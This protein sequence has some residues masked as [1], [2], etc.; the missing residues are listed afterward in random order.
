MSRTR[1]VLSMTVYGIVIGS[2][3]SSL[4]AQAKPWTLTVEERIALRTNPLLARQRVAAASKGA[5][6]DEF[7]GK[8][9]PELF[10]VLLL[11]AVPDAR[12]FG[13]QGQATDE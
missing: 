4:A 9:H 3:S 7:T 5:L 13:S 1:L 12:E 2:L 6:V 11:T 10:L 8:R